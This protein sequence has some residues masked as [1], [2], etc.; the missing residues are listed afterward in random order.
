[1]ISSLS[2]DLID[3][4]RRDGFV[5]MPGFLDAGE[6]GRWREIIDDAVAQRTERIPG[7]GDSGVTGNDYYDKVFKQRVNLWKTHASVRQFVLDPRIG[8]IAA[9]LEG[10]SSMRLYHDQAFYKER[11]GNATSWH[12]DNPYWAFHSRHATS[13]WV[14]LDDVTIQN[15]ALFEMYPEWADRTA[16]GVEMKAGDATFHNGLLAHAAGPNMTPTV[17][18]AFSVIFMPDRSTCNGHRNVLPKRL[19]DS[20]RAGDFLDDPDF[21]PL[22]YEKADD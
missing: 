22:V 12:I 13:L 7:F 3:R 10:Q 5:R 15:G 18:R 6:L 14:A 4:Y 20:L 11:W 17:R 19:F 21:N 9:Q 2:K 8:H 16:T 1:M